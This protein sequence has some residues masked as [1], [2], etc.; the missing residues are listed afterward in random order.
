VESSSQSQRPL[1]PV[2][3][4]IDRT[5]EEIEATLRRFRQQAEARLQHAERLTWARERSLQS[6]EGY[7]GRMAAILGV[8]VGDIADWNAV[9]SRASDLAERLRLLEAEQRAAQ[10][11]LRASEVATR[12]AERH[13][14]ALA[15][16]AS[17]LGLRSTDPAEILR[18]IEALAKR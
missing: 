1:A 12:R 6:L 16:V 18:A 15:R 17:R 14:A 13:A 4:A 7:L 5:Q 11:R 2:R 8:D 3:S 10:E 9:V